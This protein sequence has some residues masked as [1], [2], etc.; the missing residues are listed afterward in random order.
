MNKSEPIRPA[1]HLIKIL[2]SI[3][4]IEYLF[5][6]VDLDLVLDRV[7][8]ADILLVSLS[9]CLLLLAGS[10]LILVAQQRLFE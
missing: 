6:R 4:I 2:I 8:T 7:R 10:F 5:S 1:K 9:V 3:S